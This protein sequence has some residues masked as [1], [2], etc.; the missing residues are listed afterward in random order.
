MTDQLNTTQLLLAEW[1]LGEP[2]ARSLAIAGITGFALY[3]TRPSY[4]FKADG[5][6]RP[7]WLLTGDRN[8][9]SAS[10]LPWWSIP[11]ALGV[12]VGGL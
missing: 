9:E 12:I 4:F 6:A 5:T 1:G 10:F 7:S 8:D 11:I 2:W 3:S